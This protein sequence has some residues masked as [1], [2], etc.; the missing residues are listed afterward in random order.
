MNG[1]LGLPGRCEFQTRALYCSNRYL[2]EEVPRAA[3]RAANGEGLAS[4]EVNREGL[5]G[6][7]LVV[8]PAR[9][10]PR[11][12]KRG[13]AGKSFVEGAWNGCISKLEVPRAAKEE[14]LAGKEGAADSLGDAS[15]CSSGV[16]PKH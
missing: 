14:G 12:G 8:R 7:V 2:V 5:A 16:V 1:S 6:A 3:P 9:E 4:V 11:A 10:A 15:C 13:L